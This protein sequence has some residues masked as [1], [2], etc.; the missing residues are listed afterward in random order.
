MTH[1]QHTVW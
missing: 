1:W